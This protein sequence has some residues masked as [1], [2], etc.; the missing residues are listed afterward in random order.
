M[1]VCSLIPKK[2]NREFFNGTVLILE[3]PSPSLVFTSL[4]LRFPWSLPWFLLGFSLDKNDTLHTLSFTRSRRQSVVLLS[5][6]GAS[7][8]LLRRASWNFSASLRCTSCYY[9][10]P[11]KFSLAFSKLLLLHGL[12]FLFF[13]I[14]AT[15]DLL[16]FQKKFF[17][18]KF[19]SLSKSRRTAK[20]YN[21]RN[22]EYGTENHN[23]GTSFCLRPALVLWHL[24]C[25]F[26]A[27]LLLSA[28]FCCF[29]SLPVCCFCV[30]SYA[31][32]CFFGAAFVYVLRRSS[33]SFFHSVGSCCFLFLLLF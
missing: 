7:P 15:P 25:G 30:A 11:H 31:A 16:L 22:H 13:L 17:S 4:F 10:S 2:C 24:V 27:S 14:I 19:K 20:K 23:H 5:L 8:L 28:A 32:F 26:W 29:L 6:V 3:F 33:C 9:L 21:A 12:K 1:T 18:F